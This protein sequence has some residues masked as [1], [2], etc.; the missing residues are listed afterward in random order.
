MATPKVHALRQPSLLH[1]VAL[2]V[3]F[4]AA[5]GAGIVAADLVVAVLN[6][7][8][9]DRFFSAVENERRLGA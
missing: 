4:P 9:G 8:R 7:L 5:A 2:L 6:R 1:S 3:L